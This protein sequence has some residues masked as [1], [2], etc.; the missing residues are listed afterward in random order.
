MARSTVGPSWTVGE[1]L[2]AE[3]RAQLRAKGFR[4]LD[5]DGAIE[6]L[7]P[8]NAADASAIVRD[9]RLDATAM[10][11][12][13]RIWQLPESTM[14]ADSVLAAL[15]VEFVDPGSARPIWELHR[16]LKPIPLH[17]TVLAG[18]ANAIAAELVMREML[19]QIPGPSH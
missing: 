19:A 15:D 13:V 5:P 2:A 8:R 1:A 7:V 9:V 18:Q 4:V 10:Y 11:I 17:G 6:A 3:A 16:P 14:R 12:H